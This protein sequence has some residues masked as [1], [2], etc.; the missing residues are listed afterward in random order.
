MEYPIKFDTV[1]SGWSLYILRGHMLLF[2]KNNHKLS[3]SLK[4]DFVLTNSAD[5]DELPHDAAF[6]QYLHCLPKYPL[7]VFWYTK[8]ICSLVIR[9]VFYIPLYIICAL[10]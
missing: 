10:V 3:L 8:V 6:H 2:L 7:R 5:H 1:K 9:A 4:I